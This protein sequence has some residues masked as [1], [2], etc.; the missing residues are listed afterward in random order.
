MNLV[1]D[2]EL[3][4]I[5]KEIVSENLNLNQWREIES[6]DMFQSTNYC[7]GFDATEDAFCFSYF[8]NKNQEFWFQIKIDEVYKILSSEITEIDARPA[9]Y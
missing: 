4:Q 2:E 3:K 5:C 9:D 7:G 8:L 6:D 1:V